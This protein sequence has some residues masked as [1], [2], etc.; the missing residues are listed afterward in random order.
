M[1]VVQPPLVYPVTVLL[2]LLNIAFR[3]AELPVRSGSSRLKVSSWLRTPSQQDDLVE[4]SRGVAN[5]LHLQGLAMDIVGLVD[6]LQRLAAAWRRLGLDAVL[7]GGTT[8]QVG[9]APLPN[10][11]KV[12]LY[13]TTRPY[14]HIELDGPRL[15]ELGVDFR[16]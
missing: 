10:G 7:G 11:A 14:L 3:Q 9:E 15:R 6:D 12:P 5:S 2:Q 4:Q 13:E 8:R 1:A 16:R